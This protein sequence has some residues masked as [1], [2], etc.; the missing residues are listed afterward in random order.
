VVLLAS[1]PSALLA[2][3]R[4]QTASWTTANLAGSSSDAPALSA[5]TSG[6]VGA[7]RASAD[8]LRFTVFDGSSWSAAADVGASITTRAAPALA[9][10][11]SASYLVYH[12][13]DFMHYFGSY[14]TSWSPSAE[15]VAPS[16]AAQSFGPSAARITTLGS[17]ALVAFA[18]SDG[19]LYTQARSTSWQA[20]VPLPTSK[21]SA[22]PSIT[23]LTS[24]AD[25]LV[26]Y[27]NDDAGQ[28]DDNK[29]FWAT[30]SANVW[31]TPQKISDSIFSDEPVALASMSAG[32]ALLAFRGSDGMAYVLT[33]DPAANPLWSAAGGIDT[34]NIAVA[35]PPAVAPGGVGAL[36]ELA[37][38]ET[39]G[40][41][42]GHVRLTTS[43]WTTPTTVGGSNLTHV[44]I[45]TAP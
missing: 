14:Q 13:N 7:I 20:A 26:A 28:P 44:A 38:V 1:G 32:R 30:R 25:V 17:D 4:G 29:I 18:G 16:M 3:H 6:A 2:G 19:Q 15:P 34:P 35:S 11:G 27:I 31:S 24:G 36:A 45:A 40:G 42:V 5:T 41:A 43:G 33:Y 39:A 10:T 9:A 23:A 22:S 8:A 21:I 12:G 37:Y